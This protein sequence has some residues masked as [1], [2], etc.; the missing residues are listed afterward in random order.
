[1]HFMVSSSYLGA[2]EHD[3]SGLGKRRTSDL[4][5]PAKPAVLKLIIATNVAESSITV[6]DVRYVIDAAKQ[7]N[8]I[9]DHLHNGDKSQLFYISRDASQ[10]RL[11]RTGRTCAGEVY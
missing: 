7:R 9:R 1:M 5:A 11:G 8:T 6:P 2:H 10:Q 3:E 4:F